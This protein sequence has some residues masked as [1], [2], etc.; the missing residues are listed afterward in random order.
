MDERILVAYSEIGTKGKSTRPKF[1][2]C[3]I[4]NI[5]AT[6]AKFKASRSGGHIIL[7]P[8]SPK[9]V[10]VLKERLSRVFGVEY[11]AL[12]KQVAYS[13]LEDLADAVVKMYC[14]QIKGKVF[15]VTA[16]THETPG[17]GSMDVMRV[18]GARLVACGGKVN[19]KKYDMDVNINVRRNSAIVFDNM[20]RGPGGLP[21]GSEGNVLVLFSGGI[22]SPVAAW[23]SMRRGCRPLFLFVNLGGKD[24]LERA[25]AVYN[26]LC[27]LWGNGPFEFLVADG[28]NIV[29]EIKA[30]VSPAFRQIVLKKSFYTLAERVCRERKL[31][32][33]VT[34]ESIGQ[35]STQTLK[36]MW[37]IQRGLDV[38]FIRPLAGMDKQKIIKTAQKIGTYDV[39]IDVGELCNISKGSV[40][41]SAKPWEVEK[42][43]SKVAGVVNE[44]DVTRVTLEPAAPSQKEKKIIDLDKES[45]NPAMLDKNKFYVIVCKDGVRA[46]L[47]CDVLRGLG[48][49]CTGMKRSALTK[50]KESYPSK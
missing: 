32:A 38:L 37:G 2:R 35:V 11:Y 27:E 24:S 39:S 12:M 50:N 21:I 42:E 47:E 44:T 9:D 23:M 49:D 5:K 48:Y 6:G 26:K 34:G 33:V 43:F 4:N 30:C 19:L 18:V 17:F 7:I 16:R 13:D 8:D 3:L 40:K 29:Q 45:I 41:L 10:E 28:T 14:D 31:D 22:D 36:N 25:H 1:E 15:R 46:S 20:Y